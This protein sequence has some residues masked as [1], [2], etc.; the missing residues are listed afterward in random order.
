MKK[1]YY[2]LIVLYTASLLFSQEALTEESVSSSSLEHGVSSGEPQAKEVLS[3]KAYP[4][5]EAAYKKQREGDHKAAAVLTQ[6]ALKIDPANYQLA[7]LMMQISE[8]MQNW[9][10]VERYASLAL[11][12]RPKD[13]FAYATR[14]FAR[15][16]LNNNAGAIADFHAALRVP[17]VSEEVK[18]TATRALKYLDAEQKATL[19]AKGGA[20]SANALVGE[21][22]NVDVEAYREPTL[23]TAKNDIQR[24]VAL[25]RLDINNKNYRKAEKRL[26]AVNLDQSDNRSL[27][28][29]YSM[30]GSVYIFQNK[31]DESVAIYDKATTFAFYNFELSEM[32]WKRAEQAHLSSKNPKLVMDLAVTS[33]TFLSRSEVRNMQ[34]AYLAVSLEW[35]SLATVY[36]E[37]GFALQ[38]IK[39]R[40]Y[41]CMLDA[42]YSY[43]KTGKNAEAMKYFEKMMD[44]QSKDSSFTQHL[45]EDVASRFYASREHADIR[46]KWGSNTFGQFQ[47]RAGNDIMWQGIQEFY[48]QP[49]YYNGSLIQSYMQYANIPV[50]GYGTWG[51]EAD[52]GN[53]GLRMEPFESENLSLGVEQ[54]IKIGEAARNDTRFRVAYSLDA[55]TDLNPIKCSWNYRSSFMEYT[56]SLVHKEMSFSGFW[57]QGVSFRSDCVVRNLVTSLHLMVYLNYY[58]IAD[59]RG[60]RWFP[61]VGAGVNFRQW[62]REDRHDAPRSYFDVTVQYRVS[63]LSSDYNALVLELFNAF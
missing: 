27:Y 24:A 1:S 54:M 15:K 22:M 20:Q 62:Y 40:D 6:A 3:P 21:S 9:E 63:S 55:G 36:F 13:D 19:N 12:K 11:S 51:N 39:S 49:Y 60:H 58:N 4:L 50:S 17:H 2:Y 38:G 32:Y 23:A 10:N 44:L 14:G 18:N 8:Q 47:Q 46:R 48:Y 28:D 41:R 30:L 53:F 42:A 52:Y 33:G 31:I 26:K 34:I 16:H 56:Y 45:P 7:M 57:R 61:Y 5:V 59:A 43:K 29:Y 25:A 35:H 37:R